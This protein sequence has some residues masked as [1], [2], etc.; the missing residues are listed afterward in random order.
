MVYVVLW[1]GCVVLCCVEVYGVLWCVMWCVCLLS[2]CSRRRCA[3]Q[4]EDPIS[5]SI[6]NFSARNFENFEILDF[7][8]FLKMLNILKVSK[9]V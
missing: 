7:A 9:F 1:R 3:I 8:Y 4:N 6:G 2:L 5:R